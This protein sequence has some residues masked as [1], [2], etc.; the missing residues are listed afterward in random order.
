MARRACPCSCPF[1]GW[2]CCT[3]PG[4]TPRRC[5]A[6]R[7]NPADSADGWPRPRCRAG[8]VDRHDGV[9]RVGPGGELVP[10]RVGG[11]IVDAIRRQV[12]RGL[13][14]GGQLRAKVL[15][16]IPA[17][18]VHRFG[19]TAE[20]ARVLAGDLLVLRLRHLASRHPVSARRHAHDIEEKPLRF[21]CLQRR[22]HPPSTRAPATTPRRD[23]LIRIPAPAAT[24]RRAAANIPH[25]GC[26]ARRRSSGAAWST[27]YPAR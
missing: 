11:Q 14:A 15:G 5:P 26:P 10:L 20:N 22:Q 6:R 4:T 12:A 18:A 21:R 23:S 13:F 7:T 17:H 3:N 2:R 8:S 1:C 24:P 27:E 16:V 19:R 9:L 25:A